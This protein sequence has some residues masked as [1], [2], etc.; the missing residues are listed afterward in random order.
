MD[1]ARAYVQELLRMRPKFTLDQAGIVEP[2][3]DPAELGH[4]LEG[5]RK[6]GFPE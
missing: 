2:L 3:Q 6:S 4:L 5:L 1:Q